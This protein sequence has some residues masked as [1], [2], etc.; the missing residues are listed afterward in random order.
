MIFPDEQ[1]LNFLLADYLIRN[2]ER[3][4]EVW[5]QMTLD[6]NSDTHTKEH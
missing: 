1:K 6:G 4:S 3:S 5:K 2:T